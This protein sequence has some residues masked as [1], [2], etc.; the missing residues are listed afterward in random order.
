[1]GLVSFEMAHNFWS[2]L[3]QEEK[4]QRMGLKFPQGFSQSDGISSKTFMSVNLSLPQVST[5]EIYYSPL[6]IKEDAGRYEI[7]KKYS[8]LN[9]TKRMQKFKVHVGHLLPQELLRR[10]SQ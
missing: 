9:Y 1:L 3:T 5:G 10:Q 7:I 6:K 2:D 8:I 4:E